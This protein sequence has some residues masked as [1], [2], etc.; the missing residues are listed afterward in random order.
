MENIE[1]GLLFI[2][3]IIGIASYFVSR[4]LSKSGNNLRSRPPAVVFRIV[5]IA[6]YLLIGAAW[7]LSISYYKSKN[8]ENIDSL[9]LKSDNVVEMVHVFYSLLIVSLFLWPVVYSRGYKKTA[10]FILVFCILFTLLCAVVNPDVS[11]LCLAPLFTWL[12]FALLL[13]F[14][15]VNTM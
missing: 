12:V 4:D 3:S 1:I 7:M 14:T 13:N 10:M 5:W 9:M 8:N 15:T 6:L 2:P 11:N